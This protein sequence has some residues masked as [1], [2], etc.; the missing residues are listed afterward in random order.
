[1]DLGSRRSRH[2]RLPEIREPARPRFYHSLSHCRISS[3]EN[4]VEPPMY[5]LGKSDSRTCDLAG[6]EP[7]VNPRTVTGKYSQAERNAHSR[8]RRCMHTRSC[9]YGH[10]GKKNRMVGAVRYASSTRL[11]R[12]ACVRAARTH[13]GL[14]H[15]CFQPHQRRLLISASTSLPRRHPFIPRRIALL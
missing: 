6:G 4:D 8:A 10:T 14:H 15:R 11:A 3:C 2:R 1:M 9:T 7:P 5:A 13:T 12:Q